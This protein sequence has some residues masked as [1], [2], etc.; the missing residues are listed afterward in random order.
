MLV[1]SIKIGQLCKQYGR[2]AFVWLMTKENET[3]RG[4]EA[5][6][7]HCA[8]M[9]YVFGR[10][11]TGERNPFMPYH[12]VGADYDFMELIQDYW[13]HFA[14]NGNPNSEERPDWKQYS[15]D[16]DVILLG[17]ETRMMTTDEQEK[18]K[19]YNKKL[20]ERNT[21]E[22]TVVLGGLSRI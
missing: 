16:M 3:K 7:P 1:G 9:P 4:H 15:E 12:W 2:R 13:Y 19:Y 17:N 6:S 14:A 10:V 22:P 21:N 5:G 18:Y 8:E 11:D 20:V